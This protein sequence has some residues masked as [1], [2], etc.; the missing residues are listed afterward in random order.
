M[1]GTLLAMLPTTMMIFPC[2][3]FGAVQVSA[4]QVKVANGTYIM[5]ATNDMDVFREEYQ[6]ET[7]IHA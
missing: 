2:R 1:R 3:L 6:M 5:T 7:K 4:G